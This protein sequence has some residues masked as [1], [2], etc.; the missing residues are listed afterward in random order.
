MVRSNPANVPG[1][2]PFF[3]PLEVR[4]FGVKFADEEDFQT[5][6]ERL[7]RSASIQGT[8]YCTVCDDMTPF[9]LG[10]EYSFCMKCGTIKNFTGVLR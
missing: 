3:P 1:L 8:L 9:T 10:A 5:K 7:A 2:P 6:A 4:A